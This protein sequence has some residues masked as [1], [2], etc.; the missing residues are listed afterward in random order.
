MR[1]NKKIFLTFALCLMAVCVYTQ[2]KHIDHAIDSIKVTLNDFNNSTFF[3]YSFKPNHIIVHGK[4][5]VDS[6]S[7]PMKL[8][9]YKQY[10]EYRDLWWDVQDADI[11]NRFVN[12][13]IIIVNTPRQNWIEECQELF[14]ETEKTHLDIY[15]YQA[16]KM[17]HIFVVF[18]PNCR[19]TSFIDEYVS[20]LKYLGWF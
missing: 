20:F 13:A 16:E 9:T 3:D 15:V 14:Y 19:Y 1:V 11:V 4:K 2:E 17:K 6:I 18:E 10:H 7:K 5:T 12:Y 8:E